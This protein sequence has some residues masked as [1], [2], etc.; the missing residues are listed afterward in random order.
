M[1]N[2]LIIC[3]SLFCVYI[4]KPL[5][6]NACDF[7]KYCHP[8]CLH[9][10]TKR[11]SIIVFFGGTSCIF[12]HTFVHDDSDDWDDPFIHTFVHDAVIL[13]YVT[14]PATFSRL[15]DLNCLRVLFD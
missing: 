11:V 7:T 14:R 9:C 1:L 5:K 12:I 8:S 6:Y 4:V 13:R 3:A 15:M 2:P 10:I